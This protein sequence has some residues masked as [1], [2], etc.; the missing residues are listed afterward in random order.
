MESIRTAPGLAKLYSCKADRQSR[1]A[2]VKGI[3]SCGTT[4]K[5]VYIIGIYNLGSASLS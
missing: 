4:L 3:T 5:D 1:G 2:A